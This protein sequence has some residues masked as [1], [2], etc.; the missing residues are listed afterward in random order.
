VNSV[1][2]QLLLGR[3]IAQERR[4]HGL[5]QPELA[6]MVD[7]PVAWV[8]QLERGIQPI[9]SPKLLKTVAVALD[10]PLT[11]LTPGA[12]TSGTSN[13]ASGNGLAVNGTAVNGTAANGSTANGFAANGTAANGF[14]ANGTAVIG[15]S[16]GLASSA[17][18][19]AELR[20]ILAGVH[21]LRA[22]LGERPGP[23]A[24]WLRASTDRACTL[25]AAGRFAELTDVL[26][27]LLP[28]LETAVRAS[29]GASDRT[30]AGDLYELMAVAYQACA[31]ALARL[32]D[33][34]AAWVAADRAMAAAER[35]GNLVLV[36]AGAH[37]LASVFL[38]AQRYELAEETART[39]I[40]ALAGLAG[41]GD[42]DAVALCGGLTLL[43]AAVAARAGRLSA[44]YGQLARA[45]HLS[46]R[47]GGQQAG[48][49]PEFGPECVALYEIAVSV[50]LGDAGHALR[51]AAATDLTRLSAG[52]RARTLIDV[53]R[54]Y[55]LR[56]QV[57]DAVR[58]L[59]AAEAEGACY[60]TA[61][62]RAREVVA[63]LLALSQPPPRALADLQA[64]LAGSAAG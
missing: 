38:G 62:G 23:P 57:D 16:P 27:G 2:Y 32:G 18:V 47:L 43:R 9:D 15:T 56:E 39:T 53:A 52:R 50:D 17:A 29:T 6:A 10:L 33:T 60:V 37:R 3:R 44:A 11:E 4:R 28:G 58:A 64:R 30:D 24:G 25:A 45:R 14:A 26:A 36:A 12:T 35:A 63:D 7:R 51:V 41:L 54:A 13:G 5:S 55:A 48:G 40:D 1:E 31:A 46:A 8:S 20:V 19:A 34:E 49:F 42:P 59:A 61:S 21:S 22:M